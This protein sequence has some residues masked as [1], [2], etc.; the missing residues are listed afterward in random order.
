MSREGPPRPPR[1]PP[2]G[3]K[4]PRPPSRSPAPFDDDESVPD[5]VTVLRPLPGD[6]GDET[7]MAPRS[8]DEET[9]MAFRSGE[10]ASAQTA[11]LAAPTDEEASAQTAVLDAPSLAARSSGA[12]PLEPLEPLEERVSQHT[13][14]VR[15][16]PHD[17]A[18]AVALDPRM[19]D[20]SASGGDSPNATL[21]LAGPPNAPRAMPPQPIAFAPP[22]APSVAHPSQEWATG[23]GPHMQAPPGPHASQEWAMITGP[24]AQAPSSQHRSQAWSPQQQGAPP[25][26]H[27]QPGHSSAPY[28]RAPY[29]S[30]PGAPSAP[31]ASDDAPPSGRTGAG[32]GSFSRIFLGSVEKYRGKTGNVG[33]ASQEAAAVLGQ[34]AGS[35][36]KTAKGATLRLRSPLASRR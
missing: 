34:S 9:Q 24:P 22:P 6:E 29:A 18:R 30:A 2:F 33:S 13:Q 35:E 21:L 31:P 23:T 7:Q 10:E 25:P 16:R 28:A 14:L 20:P 8:D 19:V 36:E 4:V 32:P 26:P 3:P 27:S 1:K 15:P 5:S 12:S 11:I 17:A